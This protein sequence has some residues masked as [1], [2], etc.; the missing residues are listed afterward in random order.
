MTANKL[1]VEAA[2][3]VVDVELAGVSGHL[4]V[5]EHLLE[6]V[7]ELLAKVSGVVLVDGIDR[8]VGLLDHIHRDGSVSLFTIPGAAVG[9]AQAPDGTNKPVELRVCRRGV[10][11]RRILLVHKV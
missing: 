5:E 8:L 3:N 11:T 7:A 2:G 10:G 1:L 4:C 6:H 9:L